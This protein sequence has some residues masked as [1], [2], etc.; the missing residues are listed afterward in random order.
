MGVLIHKNLAIQSNGHPCAVIWTHGGFTPA[1]GLKPGSGMTKVPDGI[2]LLFH[3]PDDS[4]G[5]GDKARRFLEGNPNPA[6][7]TV[8]QTAPAGT[9]VRDYALTISETD[10]KSFGSEFRARHDIITVLMNRKTHL[11]DVFEAYERYHE[12]QWNEVRYFACRINKLTYTGDVSGP[13][14]DADLFAKY[15]RQ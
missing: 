14:A 7:L 10:K 6:D 1:R 4:V 5:A 9:R 11:S 3:T 2:T 15:H 12:L 13:A 8:H